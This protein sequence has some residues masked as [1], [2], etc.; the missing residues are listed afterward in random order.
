[1]SV[2]P[3]GQPQVGS[4]TDIRVL[5]ISD[6]QPQVHTTNVLPTFTA[7]FPGNFTFP[8]DTGTGTAPYHPAGT[9]AGKHNSTVILPT[10][11]LSVPHSL[12]T[13]KTT[14]VGTGKAPPATPNPTVPAAG[15][16]SPV[17]ANPNGAGRAFAATGLIGMVGLAAAMLL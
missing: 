16:S 5:Q 17:V 2:K 15:P 3:D 8:H 14:L 11:S 9:G 1:M 4:S 13:P 10:K 6:G 12:K 7:T